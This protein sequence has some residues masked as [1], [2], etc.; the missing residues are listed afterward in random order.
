MSCIIA[1]RSVRRS[2]SLAAISLY[3]GR[4]DV[5]EGQILQLPFHLPDAQPVGQRGEQLQRFLGDGLSPFGR[6]VVE[7]A[8]VVQAV[9]QLDDHHAHIVAHGEENLPQG[10]HVQGVAAGLFVL[11]AGPSIVAGD[12]RQL[13]EF[14]HPVHEFGH[15]VAEFRADIFQRD[16]RVFHGVVQQAGGDGRARQLQ[17]G[18]D[19]CHGQAVLD[20]RF[21]GGAFLPSWARDA[22]W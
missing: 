8:H 22:I 14:G 9:G 10:F 11:R 16:G 6:Q 3:F 19:F 4:V 15:F 2:S 20:I 1:S 21:P 13:G 5:Q 7:G 17:I 18:Q 12:A